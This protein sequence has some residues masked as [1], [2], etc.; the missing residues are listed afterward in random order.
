MGLELMWIVLVVCAIA[1]AVGFYK[2]VYFLSIGYGFAIAAGAV[3][4]AVIFAGRMD[5]VAALQMVLFIAYGARLSG[6]LLVRELKSASFNKAMKSVMKPEKPLPI[7]VSVSIWVCVAI[8]YTMQVSPMFYRLYNSTADVTMPVIGAVISVLGLL[9]E[10]AADKQKSEQ[11]KKNPDMVATEG[12]YRIVRCPNYLGEIIFWT[13]VLVGAFTALQG[14]GQWI[15][16]ILAWVLIVFIMC[17][18]AQRLEKRQM[19]RYGKDKAYSDYAN[20]TPI[21]FPFVPLYHLNKQD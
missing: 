9:L 5:W 14:A 1:C 4:T 20:K 7:F 11:K 17:N 18:G 12:L 21:I 19:A 2:Y 15:V 3:A 16:A 8:L 10:S 6:F 13:G